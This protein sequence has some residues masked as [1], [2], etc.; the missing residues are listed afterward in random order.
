[1]PVLMATTAG[2]L[3]AGY[4]DSLT[5]PM[6]VHLAIF[7]RFSL[8]ELMTTFLVCRFWHTHAKALA[9]KD[10]QSVCV[11]FPEADNLF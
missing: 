4:Y 3:G 7:G 9:A 8:C 11:Q 2:P 5:V 10:G 1:M 6:S